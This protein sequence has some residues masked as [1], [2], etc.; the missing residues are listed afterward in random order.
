MSRPT[1]R[2]CSSGWAEQNPNINACEHS[3]WSSQDISLWS[4]PLQPV[5]FFVQCSMGPSETRGHGIMVDSRVERCRKMSKEIGAWFSH[6]GTQC[7]HAYWWDL[8]RLDSLALPN[9]QLF[10][11]AFLKQEWLTR[12]YRGNVHEAGDLKTP[13]KDPCQWGNDVLISLDSCVVAS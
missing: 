8:M 5:S 1:A 12:S 11:H 3:V 9:S 4:H 7:A 2:N 10:L 13:M 6:C